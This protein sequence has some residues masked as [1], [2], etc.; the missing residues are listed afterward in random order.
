MINFMA[1][2]HQLVSLLINSLKP[3][4]II[5]VIRQCCEMAVKH[6]LILLETYMTADAEFKIQFLRRFSK[7]FFPV[8]V[9]QARDGNFD[10]I[11]NR[12]DA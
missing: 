12:M 10:K 6:P 8:G 11:E 4:R 2:P 7:K 5:I 3:R 1:N 9:G